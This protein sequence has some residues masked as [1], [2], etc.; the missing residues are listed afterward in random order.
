[1]QVS[2]SK[3][4]YSLKDDVLER[5]HCGATLQEIAFE[6]S[7]PYSTV[8]YYVKRYYRGAN[9]C[10]NLIDAHRAVISS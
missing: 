1:M 7:V 6:L 8:W 3:Y 5:Y 9:S 2:M 4:H 10:V